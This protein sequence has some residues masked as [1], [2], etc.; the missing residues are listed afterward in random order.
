[1]M[2]AFEKYILNSVLLLKTY[3]R[4]KD[5]GLKVFTFRLITF[6][7]NTD[8]KPGIQWRHSI[9]ALNSRA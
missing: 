4:V 2:H 3:M 7:N 8:T 1:M 9:P 5:V 6:E